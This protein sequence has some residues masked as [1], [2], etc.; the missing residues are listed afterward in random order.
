[1]KEAVVF[2]GQNSLDFTEVRSRVIRIPE[3]SLRIEEAQKIW[4][5]YCGSSFSF[6]HFLISENLAFFN[7]I[8]LKS[9]A[10]S[11]VQLGLL[12]RYIRIFR[13][14]EVIVG[15]VQ[16]DSALMVAAGI[17]QFS[18]MI[19]KSQASCLVR[20]MAPLH[21][22]SE[23]VLKGRSLPLY[24]S[25]SLVEG[26]KF[27]VL[28]ASDMNLQ[29]ILQNLIDKQN[30]T[31]IVHVGPGFLNKTPGLEEILSR[32]VQVVESIDV[33]PMLGWFWSDLRKQ[34]LPLA[35]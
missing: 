2:G 12:D 20:P 24:Q 21:D 13:N 10:L 4:D 31:K 14:P 17:I 30:V 35:Q 8:N 5:K 19:T 16:N 26:E 33:D 25:Y 29:V 6:Q 18:E 11:I 9:L 23:L 1:M 28:G 22:V 3:V 27:Q 34:E 7:N 32:D 15:N